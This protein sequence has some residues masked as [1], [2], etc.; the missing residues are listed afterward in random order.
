[1]S[2]TPPPKSDFLRIMTERGY[3]HQVSDTTGIDA[4]AVK[5][6]LTTYVGY[7]CTAPSFHVG[8]LL[9]IMMLHWLQQTGN[10]PDR[11]HG[12]RHHAAWGTPRVKDEAS[13]DPHARRHQQANKD[14]HHE[15]YVRAGCSR[16]TADG[17]S[18]ALA[19]STMPNGSPS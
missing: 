6:E 8:N 5:G 16:F 9:S 4:L 1:M 7:D 18:D 14:Q 15:A 19:W 10:K 11:A 13:P 2:D 12:R 17:A 3:L